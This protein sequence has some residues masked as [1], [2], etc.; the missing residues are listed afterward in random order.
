MIRKLLKAVL[1][2]IL[3]RL[4]HNMAQVDEEKKP[5]TFRLDAIHFPGMSLKEVEARKDVFALHDLQ[6][7]PGKLLFFKRPGIWFNS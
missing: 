7:L 5:Q 2:L 6:A 3:A 4:A 1:L